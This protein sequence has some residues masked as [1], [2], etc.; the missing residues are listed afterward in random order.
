MDTREST[1]AYNNFL[2]FE[3]LQVMPVR[4]MDPGVPEF[5]YLLGG[6]GRGARAIGELKN[7]KP[8]NQAFLPVGK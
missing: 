5:L 6:A 3:K 2:T 1:W 8:V 4:R 7:R